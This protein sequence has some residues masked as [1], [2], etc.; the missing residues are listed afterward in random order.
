VGRRALAVEAARSFLSHYVTPAGRVVRRDQ[1]GDTVSEGQGYALLLAFAANDRGTFQRVWAWTRR[2]LRVGTGLFAWRWSG[3]HAVSNESAADADTQIAWALDL[4]G[5]AWSIHS[6]LRAARAAA[7]AVAAHEVGHDSR[8][9]PTLAGGPWAVGPGQ[10]AEVEPGYWT[11]PADRALASLTGDHRWRRLDASDAAH[12]QS[13]SNGGRQ[14][15]SDW[16]TVGSGVTPAPE[17][18]GG[19]PVQSGPDGQRGLVWAWC[20]SRTHSLDARWWQLIDGSASSGAMTRSLSGQPTSSAVS[21]LGLVAAAAAAAAAG[22]PTSSTSLLLD[23]D[24]AV[25]R[26]PTYYG[27]AWDALGRILLTTHLLPGCAA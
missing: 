1:G 8:G 20:D 11:F 15:P 19:A 27:S 16:A 2:N 7:E 10:P 4:A 24:R 21:P 25:R 26:F 23:A 22:H 18:G 13:L 17:P 12:L 14:L 5:R 9:R 3:G 6:Y